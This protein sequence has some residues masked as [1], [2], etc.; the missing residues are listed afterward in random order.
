MGP[1]QKIAGRW[2][3][4]QW[5]SEMDLGD[6]VLTFS[7]KEKKDRK[8]KRRKEVEDNGC[9]ALDEEKT[10]MFET[11]F[12][13]LTDMDQQAQE[14]RGDSRRR[15]IGRLSQSERHLTMEEELFPLPRPSDIASPEGV[16]TKKPW[17]KTSLDDLGCS[18][19][20]V[21]GDDEL[22]TEPVVVVVASDNNGHTR[23]RSAPVLPSDLAKPEHEDDIDDALAAL[24]LFK[25]TSG[26]NDDDVVAPLC[27]HADSPTQQQ[28]RRHHPFVI[29]HDGNTSQRDEG[30]GF[31]TLSTTSS[32]CVSEEQHPSNTPHAPLSSSTAPSSPWLL[33]SSLTREETIVEDKAF[34]TTNKNHSFN[35]DDTTPTLVASF[36][37]AR[38]SDDSDSTVQSNEDLQHLLR[39]PG[40]GSTDLYAGG[41]TGDNDN[42]SEY[43]ENSFHIRP[44]NNA[45]FENLFGDENPDYYGPSMDGHGENIVV[46]CTCY[47]MRNEP[48]ARKKK[49]I[50]YNLKNFK[51]K[52]RRF[53]QKARDTLSRSGSG[54][55]DWGGGSH[56]TGSKKSDGGSNDGSQKD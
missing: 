38:L 8:Q 29:K 18:N 5:K 40:M 35:S 12:V 20:W 15:L 14:Q 9:V 2:S 13:G 16:H 33:R 30:S 19:K 23:T 6:G 11:S 1:K 37:N 17:L 51:Q 4:P 31:D 47:R 27:G 48:K 41:N 10:P 26:S 7:V 49:K 53:H 21:F 42:M 54:R 3:A 55:M 56:S 34:E 45:A 28:Q 32:S 39:I 43:T 22:L 36:H 50:V 25:S 44:A 24:S 52:S 46:E